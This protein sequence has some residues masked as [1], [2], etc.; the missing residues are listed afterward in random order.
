MMTNFNLYNDMMPFTPGNNNYLT[1]TQNGTELVLDTDY[2][3]NGAQ[4]VFTYPP[5]MG[6]TVEMT[7]TDRVAYTPTDPNDVVVTIDGVTQTLGS[8]YTISGDQIVFA[9]AQSAP[10]SDTLDTITLED[11]NDTNNLTKKDSKKKI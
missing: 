6:D 11:C 7:Y 2:T 3:I 9:A 8:D 5:L 4:I 10:S 1:V